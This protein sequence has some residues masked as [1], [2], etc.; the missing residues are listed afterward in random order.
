M[1]EQA[2]IAAKPVLVPPNGVTLSEVFK[3]IR[4][5]FVLVSAAA[6][7]I[8]VALSATFLAAYLSVFD[9]HLIWFVQYTDIITFGL[10]ALGIVSGSVIFLQNFV[11]TILAGKTFEQRR[12]G[13]VIMIVLALAGMALNVWSEAHKGH[14]YFHVFSGATAF[15]GAVAL[16]LLIAVQ[17]ETRK[18][19]TAI[20]CLFW[21]LLLVIIS[22]SL[23]RW[24]GEN[25][26]ETAD[27]NQDVSVKDQTLSDVKLIIVFV[28]HTVLLKDKIVYVVPTADITKFQTADRTVKPKVVP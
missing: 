12:N 8:G 9:W 15:A 4:E 25:V 5:N 13:L 7:L 11:Q 10:L 6:V 3:A 19:P 22:G 16:V 24:L 26:Q 1:S 27:F 28:R 18:L 23:G 21:L 20:Q 17:V 14:G 2:S